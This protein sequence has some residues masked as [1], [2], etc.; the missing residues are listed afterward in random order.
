MGCR[1]PGVLCKND[2]TNLI[3]GALMYTS[4]L[5]LFLQF[6]V[7]KYILG[8]TPSMAIQTKKLKPDAAPGTSSLP[9]QF[10]KYSVD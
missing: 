4:Y 7:E 2:P 9:P 1:Q 10:S 5:L 8:R 6:F 3:A